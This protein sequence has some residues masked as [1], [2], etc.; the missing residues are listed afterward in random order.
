M[1]KMSKRGDSY[2]LF[3]IMNNEKSRVFAGFNGV[4]R[5]IKSCYNLPSA[6]RGVML[7]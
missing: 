4:T 5:W 6:G 3:V 7:I 1:Y 2:N